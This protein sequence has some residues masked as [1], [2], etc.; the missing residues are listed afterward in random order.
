M[1]ISRVKRSKS[2]AKKA[3]DRLSHIYDWLAG[4]SETQFMHL[5]L[6][7]LS[8]NAGETILEVGSGTGKALV[9]LCHQAGNTGKVHALDLSQG[10][11]QKSRHR[12][13]NAGMLHRISLLEGDGVNLPYKNGSFCAVFI[14]FTLE[15]FDTPEIPRVLE[16]CWR[17]L[18]PNGRLGVVSMLKTEHPGSAVRL[19]EWFHAHFPAYVDCRPMDAQAMIQA[20]GFTVEKRQVRSMWG[21]PVELVAARKK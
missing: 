8:I 2:A 15:L 9:E 14:S 19:Y 7:M 12:L 16:E 3:Y 18:T 10:M 11:L 21:L 1:Q 17:V 6:E 4:S 5:G 20:T 13:V